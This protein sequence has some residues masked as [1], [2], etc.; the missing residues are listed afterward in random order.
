MIVMIDPMPYALALERA[1]ITPRDPDNAMHT[2][3]LASAAL[4]GVLIEMGYSPD[5]GPLVTPDDW[6][7]HHTARA[8][9]IAG[10]LYNMADNVHVC[11]EPSNAAAL[12][13]SWLAQSPAHH[14]PQFIEALTD[15]LH[16]DG[17]SLEGVEAPDYVCAV[18]DTAYLHYM[19]DE[20][21]D[22]ELLA[23][24]ATPTPPAQ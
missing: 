2:Y 7:R 11:A 8:V 9:W 10:S 1:S 18:F 22:S 24:P 21:G 4:M 14:I 19:R 6:A 3:P 5:A 12:L 20:R 23:I 15:A 16:T 17:D 13:E